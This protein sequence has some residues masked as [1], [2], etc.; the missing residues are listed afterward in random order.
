[1]GDVNAI[2]ERLQTQLGRMDGPP[3]PLE[4]GITN[5]N[6]RVVFDG[7][8]CV[9]RLPGKDTQLLGISRE[10]EWI[11]NQMAA[12]LGLA[13]AVLRAEPDCLVTEFVA[14]RAISSAEV[15]DDPEP[16]GRALRA[17]HTSGEALPV[18]FWVPELLRAYA[19]TV[20]ERGGTLP[21]GYRRAQEIA[22]QIADV[23]PLSD[24]VPCHDDLLSANLMAPDG[25]GVMLV[26]W[27]YAGMGHRGFD[28]GNLAVNNE[29]DGPAEDRLLEAYFGEPADDR[30]RAELRL[31]RL[32]SDAREGAWGVV[33]SVLSE[34]EFDFDA[35][36]SQ[37]F[38]RL[39]R[40]AGD[41]SFGEWIDAAAA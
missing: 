31:M 9:V 33:Q 22:G 28:L 25:G 36:A 17:I 1:M 2:M 35:Y 32:M 27:E 29:F 30:R 15:R 24:P 16:F 37:H 39:E 5:R 21:D 18:T 14:G 23:L 19:A 38:E 3:T 12:R 11:A 7:R 34:I 40:A 6:Y 4:G 8:D 13:P 26:D 41:D 20:D 10:A